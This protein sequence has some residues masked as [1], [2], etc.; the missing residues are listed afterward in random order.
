[1]PSV[2]ANNKEYTAAVNNFINTVEQIA[3]AANTGPIVA[4][5]GEI[6]KPFDD[7]AKMFALGADAGAIM[8]ISSSG[9]SSLSCL[10]CCILIILMVFMEVLK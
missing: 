1:M 7:L 3:K 8:C 9:S 10:C 6:M 4:A 5:L 2:L